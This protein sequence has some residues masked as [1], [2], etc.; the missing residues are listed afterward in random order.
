MVFV[1]K[2]VAVVLFGLALLLLLSLGIWQ[3]NRGLQKSSVL[4]IVGT[5]LQEYQTLE[6]IP[7]DF[8]ALEYRTVKLQGSWEADRYFL[9]DNRIHQ[10]RPGYEVLAPFRLDSGQLLLVNRG[11]VGKQEV[12]AIP[13]LQSIAPVGTLYYPEKGYTIGES[14]TASAGWPKVSL[15]L[16]M[17]VFSEKL[18][19]DLAPLMLV[20]EEEN[21]NSLVRLWKPVVVTPE[22][23]YAY[24]LQW[25]GLA[26]VLLVF[27]FIWRKHI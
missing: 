20:M 25:F 19:E 10:R 3:T 12:D 2:A 9:H 13:A 16:D 6:E 14:I 21:P 11:W 1:K 15:Y 24:A 18:G 23:H 17:P 26:T 7:T 22:R 27:G 8:Q 4:S 5:E